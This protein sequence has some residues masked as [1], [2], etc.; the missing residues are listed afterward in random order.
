MSEILK[1]TKRGFSPIWMLLIVLIFAI[2]G[3][4]YY[5]FNLKQT[6]EPSLPVVETTEIAP[7][8]SPELSNST[9]ANT[10]EKELNDTDLGEFETDLNQLD[11]TANQL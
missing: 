2:V 1:Q 9:D 4:S 8:P 11:A 6:I 10:L 7:L 3:G 5:Y